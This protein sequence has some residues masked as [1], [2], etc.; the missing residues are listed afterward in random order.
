[1]CEDSWVHDTS[2][3]PVIH[4]VGDVQI[5]IAAQEGHRTTRTEE[6]GPGYLITDEDIGLD[7]LRV[8]VET[9]EP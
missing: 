1:M 2:N 5:L 4:D 9:T 3:V 7:I 8:T 6:G